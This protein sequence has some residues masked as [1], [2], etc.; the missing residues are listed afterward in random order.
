MCP[1]T[2]SGLHHIPNPARTIHSNGIVF[3][4]GECGCCGANAVSIETADTL[5]TLAGHSVN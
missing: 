3:R 2:R 4:F 5:A 1:N